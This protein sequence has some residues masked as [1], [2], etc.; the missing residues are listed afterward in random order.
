M[1]RSTGR[2]ILKC[3]PS[4]RKRFVSSGEDLAAARKIFVNQREMSPDDHETLQEYLRIPECFRERQQG[5]RE[6]AAAFVPSRKERL[7]DQLVQ[8]AFS[9]KDY[10]NVSTFTSLEEMMAA[11]VHFGHKKGAWNP[12]MKRFILGTRFD[13]HIINLDHTKSYLER[14]LEF[15]CHCVYIG[16][17]VVFV[18]SRPHFQYLTQATARECGQYFITDK[19]T[20]GKLTDP[21]GSLGTLRLPDL[22]ICTSSTVCAQGILEANHMGIPTIAVV[23]TDADPRII[24]YPVP[25]NDDSMSSIKLFSRIFR[26]AIQRAQEKRAQDLLILNRQTPLDLENAHSN[27]QALVDGLDSRYDELDRKCSMILS[28]HG[29]SNP[30]Y[31]S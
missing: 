10:F 30:H 4:I 20:T 3:A 13:T 22:M 5:L 17:R 2:H 8:R 29:P 9:Q 19:W 7:E 6:P 14:A 24:T 1:L 26:D 27:V 25:G 12:L 31:F 15:L 11:G 18:N 16:L 21:M 23:D 28:S